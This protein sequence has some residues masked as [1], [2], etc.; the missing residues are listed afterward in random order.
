MCS[1]QP[2]RN[3]RARCPEAEMSVQRDV[4]LQLLALDRIG[5]GVSH[6]ELHAH[7]G[8]VTLQAFVSA[9]SCLERSSLIEPRDGRLYLTRALRHLHRLDLI[10]F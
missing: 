6:A 10:A 3:C 5:A 9:L 4:L 2:N 8:A 7:L 1:R